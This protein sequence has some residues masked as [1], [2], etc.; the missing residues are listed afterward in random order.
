MFL[1]FFFCTINSKFFEFSDLILKNKKIIKKNKQKNPKLNTLQKLHIHLIF[2]PLN[3]GLFQINDN[4]IGS[5][6]YIYAFVIE[7]RV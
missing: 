7:T 4:F 2:T 6:L 1:M 3:S 5:K